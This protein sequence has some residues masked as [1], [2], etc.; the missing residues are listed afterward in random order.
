MFKTSRLQKNVSKKLPTL[1]NRLWN[2]QAN[3]YKEERSCTCK[4]Y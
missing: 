4:P 1:K 2:Q 3:G